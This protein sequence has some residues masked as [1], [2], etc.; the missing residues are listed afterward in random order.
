MAM[1]AALVGEIKMVQ[2][3]WNLVDVRALETAETRVVD[4]TYRAIAKTQRSSE[5]DELTVLCIIDRRKIWRELGHATIIEY[6][7]D[8]YGY[9][10][11][12][13]Y[14]RLR[15]AR[16]LDALPELRESLANGEASYSALRE[17]TR[18]VTAETQRQ[19]LD[20]VRGRS[21]RE[22]EELVQTHRKGE[23]PTDPPT[24]NLAPVKFQIEV[25]RA[26]HAMLRH[27]RNVLAKERGHSID[28]DELYAAMATAVIA[29][30]TVYR[31]DKPEVP[32]ERPPVIVGTAKFQIRTTVCE[33]CEQT[34]FEGAGRKI[35]VTAS[36][37]AR[38]QCD[39]QRIG[40]DLRATQDVSPTVR[41]EVAHR[42]GGNCTVP[43]C[44]SA[45]NLEIHHVVPREK[46]GKHDA[47]NLTSLCDGHHKAHHDGKLV[48][49]GVAPKLTFELAH[50]IANGYEIAVMKAEAT[51]T[52]SQLGF[53]GAARDYVAAALQI[54]PN[55][56]SVEA[57]IRT[58]LKCSRRV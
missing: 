7:D 16:A 57:L 41:R 21:S 17:I 8:V 24:P 10:P 55:P 36:D 54:D 26:T 37:A 5:A 28:D 47:S 50:R 35:A 22:I 29:G 44:R 18:V 51:Q 23:L 30:S 3:A 27:A 14:D 39:A 34:F 13:A 2:Y 11:K 49:T 52:L 48:I 31:A 1:D 42:D 38:A 58:A 19:W 46:G 43:G 25:S 15:V 53:K 20:S 6:I 45:R 12:V 32:D 4:R 9:G 40:P 33:R 56:P